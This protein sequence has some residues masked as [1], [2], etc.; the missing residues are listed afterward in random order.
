M[1]LALQELKVAAIHV[2]RK[3]KVTKG[4][5]TQVPENRR[6]KMLLSYLF[7]MYVKIHL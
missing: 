2:L 3:V 6:K 5:K 7:Q 4:D 1:R